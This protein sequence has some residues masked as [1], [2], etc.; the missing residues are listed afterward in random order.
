[1]TA[2]EAERLVSEAVDRLW[3]RS[4]SSALDNLRRRG[5]ADETIRAF[6]LGFDPHVRATRKDGSPYRAS[7][8]VIPWVEQNRLTLIKVRQPEGRK[9]KYAEVYRHN[10]SLYGAAPILPGRP[11]VVTEGELDAVLVSQE[12]S[13]LACGVVT[14][15][16]A[17]NRPDRAVAARLVAAPTWLIGHDADPA[18]DKAASAWEQ[19][20]PGRCRRVR[21]PEKDWTDAHA[22]GFGRI[23][24]HLG[25]LVMPPPRWEQL[26]EAESID[27]PETD[28]SAIVNGFAFDD[29]EDLAEAEAR[30]WEKGQPA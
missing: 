19:L 11:V 14:T 30:Q 8:I 6:R 18:G 16:S 15:G 24:Y 28:L 9:P 2:D 12:L 4:G 20:A 23:V 26:A 1:M 25:R 17:S 22:L 3:S 7:G 29:P 13:H 27:V 10:P 21:P 5:L